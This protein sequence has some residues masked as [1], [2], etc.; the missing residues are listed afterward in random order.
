MEKEVNKANDDL[1]KR[2]AEIDKNLL[3]TKKKTDE[4]IK[5]VEEL[6]KTGIP[7][8]EKLPE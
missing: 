6:K 1:A 5:A 2:K 7:I 4:A 8:Q 3:L